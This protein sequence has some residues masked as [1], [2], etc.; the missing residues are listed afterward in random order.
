MK[1]AKV[2]LL[3]NEW[4]LKNINSKLF[5]SC[6]IYFFFSSSDDEEESPTKNEKADEENGKE[7]S[8]ERK[9]EEKKKR[10]EKKKEK[11]KKKIVAPPPLLPR[12][13]IETMVLFA[14][15]SDFFDKFAERIFA[16][17]NLIFY[18]LAWKNENRDA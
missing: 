5:L 17:T 11:E 15:Y 10:K 8:Q 2:E 18:R 6:K 13:Q 3:F 7:E 12:E 1:N 14:W 16:F 9:D 4:K